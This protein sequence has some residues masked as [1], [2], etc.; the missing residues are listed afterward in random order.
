MLTLYRDKNARHVCAVVEREEKKK[1]TEL[2]RIR[3]ATG[4]VERKEGRR[5]Y[6]TV[7]GMEEKIIE[8]SRCCHS[9]STYIQYRT[10]RC[11]VL[12]IYAII[13]GAR[14]YGYLCISRISIPSIR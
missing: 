9:E 5:H 14:T 1:L 10:I 8:T 13:Q 3:V 2:P 6:S 4:K 12:Y 11:L 7:N